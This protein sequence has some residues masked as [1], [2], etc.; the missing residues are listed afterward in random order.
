MCPSRSRVSLSSPAAPSPARLSRPRRHLPLRTSSGSSPC[1]LPTSSLDDTG[2]ASRLRADQA[3]G[4]RVRQPDESCGRAVRRIR[5]G[6]HGRWD[7]HFFRI[8]RAH[9]DD[10]E[11]AARA[12]LAIADEVQEY[13]EEVLRAWQVSDFNV[14]IGMNT[15]EAESAS[16]AVPRPRRWRWGTRRTWQRGCRAS[17]PGLDRRR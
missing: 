10:P 5:P 4:R 7:R 1:C 15:G 3:G 11:R 14:R 16:S 12:A 6:L 17:P 9:E 8:P 2:R 13:A